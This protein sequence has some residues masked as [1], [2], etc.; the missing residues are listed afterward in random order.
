LLG[1]IVEAAVMES[2]QALKDNDLDRSRRVLYRDLIINRK[3]Y[4][5]ETSIIV[6]MATQGPIGRDLRTLTASLGI[7]TELERM[8]D[9]AKGI[10][11]INL[12]SGGLSMPFVLR[13]INSMAE[14]ALD[15]LHQ[16]LTAFIE[17]D[18]AAAKSL[19][20]YDDVIDECYTKLYSEAVNHVIGDPRNIERSNYII[21]VAHNLE[22]LGDRVTNICERVVY[23]VT[24]EY[25]EEGVTT[26]GFARLNYKS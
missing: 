26:P 8:G 18:D 11:I 22:R 9:Y 21:W 6:L 24:G 7:C 13:E 20:S 25:L 16:A 4:E 2:V 10:A 19:I 3:R 12:R 1:S 15:M 5:I 17:A 14:K 23:M